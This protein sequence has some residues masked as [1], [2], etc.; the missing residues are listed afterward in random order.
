MHNH[1]GCLAVSPQAIADAVERAFADD[2]KICRGWTANITRL[3][4]PDAARDNARFI[5]DQAGMVTPSSQ[6]LPP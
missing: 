2:G 1:A 5:L 6:P 4:R 3:S